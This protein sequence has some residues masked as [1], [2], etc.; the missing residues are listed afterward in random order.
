ML[1]K[2]Y[3]HY[4]K[5]AFIVCFFITSLL[6]S[7]EKAF[8]LKT[9]GTD[10]VSIFNDAWKTLNERYVFFS[11]KNVNWDS[12]YAV[13]RPQITADISSDAL[14]TVLDNMMQT[15]RDGHVSLI[16]STKASTYGGF[17]QLYLPNFNYE[18]IINNY[19]HNDYQTVGPI[20]Y[21]ISDDIGYLYYNSFANNITNA[22]V[23]SVIAAMTN[24]KG[25]IIDVRNNTGGNTENTD[26]LFQRF[27]SGQTLV[28]YE[29]QKSG[30]GHD[31]FFNPTAFYLSPQG[32]YYNKPICVLTNRG[33][34]SACNDFVMYMS[35]LPNVTLIGDNTGGGGGIPANYL[36]AN[37]WKIQYTATATLT[38]ELA[39]IENGIEPDISINITPVDEMN[40]KDPI[41]DKAIEI[42][43]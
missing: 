43:Q 22:Q 36:L 38:P 9:P 13:Y 1:C 24:T 15:L 32:N 14:F 4:T 16:T 39:Y 6:S 31:E 12:V 7:C 20:I 27:I 25:L 30:K 10:A 28:K 23:D 34:F 19:L 11:L 42:L 5:F 18:N 8:D 29:K 33:C 35:Q 3:N 21:K 37:G 41:L 40:G 26:K 17:Y 2:L